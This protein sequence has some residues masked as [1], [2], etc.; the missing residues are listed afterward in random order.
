MQPDQK[1]LKKMDDLAEKQRYK[2]YNITDSALF[3]TFYNQYYVYL[4]IFLCLNQ[5]FYFLSISPRKII[6]NEFISAQRSAG[7]IIIIITYLF[8]I[9]IRPVNKHLIINTENTYLMEAP[10]AASKVVQILN[11]GH[12][13]VFI[14]SHDIW[15]ETEW[16]GKKN[17]YKPQKRAH[18]FGLAIKLFRKI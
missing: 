5:Q 8:L 4:V 13:L 1:I 3:W 14:N 9:N 6:R 7:A 12:R 18:S 17:F 2:G 15:I 11:R 16:E 10:S